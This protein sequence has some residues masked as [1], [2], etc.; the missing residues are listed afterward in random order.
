M[1]LQELTEERKTF[2][3]K[4]KW[5]NAMIKAGVDEFVRELVTDKEREDGYRVSTDLIYA[6]TSKGT[7]LVGSWSKQNQ[8]IKYVKPM[9]FDKRRRKFNKVKL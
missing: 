5:A 4:N 7:S 2:T 9:S 3:D 1:K 6:L 8:G